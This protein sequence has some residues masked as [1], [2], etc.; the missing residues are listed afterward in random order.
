MTSLKSS[1]LGSSAYLVSP[2][3]RRLQ[4]KSPEIGQSPVRPVSAGSKRSSATILMRGLSPQS[5]NESRR[6]IASVATRS[7][8]LAAGAPTIGLAELRDAAS[9]AGFDTNPKDRI[10][11]G[12]RAASDAWGTTEAWRIGVREARSL[13]A[14]VAANGKPISNL[15]LADMAGV[16]P[17][18]FGRRPGWG[19]SGFVRVAGVVSGPD[20][21]ALQM[22]NRPAL[23]PR[24]PF[25]GS[26]FLRRG[27]RTTPRRDSLLH[28]SPE[29]TARIRR[30]VPCAQSMPSTTIS[31][32]TMPK[33]SWTRPPATSES[34]PITIRSLLVN[35]RPHRARRRI[36]TCLIVCSG[37]RPGYAGHQS[38]V[39]RHRP[40][41]GLCGSERIPSSSRPR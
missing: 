28:L 21:V 12:A 7:L 34:R 30:R 40:E 25:G 38:V 16:Q 13:R 41:Q 37:H 27:S 6:P 15:E 24:A 22:G 35:N 1:W 26:C 10:A 39:I 5:A 11:V 23:R 20:R 36:L 17:G 19:G 14:H 8:E 4:S 3:S 9:R 31:L 18:G 33:T 32:V 29:G 2:M